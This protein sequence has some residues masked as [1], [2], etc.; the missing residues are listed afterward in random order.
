MLANRNSPLGF[1][2]LVCVGESSLGISLSMTSPGF[3]PDSAPRRKSL[4]FE[5]EA[6]KWVNIIGLSFRPSFH[7]NINH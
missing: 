7:W 6:E 2:C 3:N 5:S 1:D 4:C